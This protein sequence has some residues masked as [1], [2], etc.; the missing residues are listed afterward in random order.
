MIKR[1]SKISCIIFLFGVMQVQAQEIAGI[2]TY[3]TK[4]TVDLEAFG[5]SNMTPQMKEQIMERMK[6]M[7]EKTYILSFTK[8]ESLYEEEESLAPEGSFAAMMGGMFSQGATYTHLNNNLFAQESELMGKKFLIKDTLETVEWK[9]EKESK[10]IGQYAAFKATAVKK[11]DD[12]MWQK[13]RERA[14][15]WREK[16]GEEIDSTMLKKQE[17]LLKDAQNI[18]V[19]YTPQI[20]VKHGPNSYHGL[21][22]LILE[23][24]VGN[25]IILCSKVILNPKEEIEIEM[26]DSGEEVTRK[27]FAKITE[28]KT[29]EMM[30]RYGGGSRRG[31]F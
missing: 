22:G 9:L 12:D 28:E 19:W 11:A 13:A 23:V 3:K 29:Q 16:N 17:K 7:L 8:E 4:T 6:S 14:K 26:P 1:I 31:G 20:P 5:A 30:N 10:M 21:P 24:N 27:E 15:E 25:T 2:A 18:T